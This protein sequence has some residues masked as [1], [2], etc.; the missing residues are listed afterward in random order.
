VLAWAERHRGVHAQMVRWYRDL[1]ALRRAE[2]DLRADDLIQISVTVGANWLVMHR[3]AFDVLVNLAP[4]VTDLPTFAAFDPVLSWLGPD[5]STGAQ[6]ES[7]ALS[8][9]LRLPPD[10]VAIV[11]GRSPR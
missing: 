4:V 6:G 7:V 2:P 3:G 11:R 8:G 5:P 10:S 9:A 1:I